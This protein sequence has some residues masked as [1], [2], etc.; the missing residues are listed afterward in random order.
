MRRRTGYFCA[1]VIA[2]IG[3]LGVSMSAAAGTQ[4]QG[5]SSLFDPVGDALD[6]Q[7]SRDYT[8]VLGHRRGSGYETKWTLSFLAGSVG[9]ATK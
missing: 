1:L 7:L 6:I 8:P 5:T 3:L 4:A 9:P 2:S